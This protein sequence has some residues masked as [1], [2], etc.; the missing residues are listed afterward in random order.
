MSDYY[1]KETESG[2]N[3]FDIAI[4]E[5]G[6]IEKVYDMLKDN[7][8]TSLDLLIAP[9]E[10]LKIQKTPTIENPNLMNYFRGKRMVNTGNE[11]D[12]SYSNDYSNDYNT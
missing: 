1:Y 5:Y 10:L 7:E 3:L 8:L 12:G 4:Q 9:G 6:D 11:V 2:Q